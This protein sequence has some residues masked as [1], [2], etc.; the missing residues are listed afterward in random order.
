MEK[1]RTAG[2]S[3]I[4]LMIAVLIIGILAAIAIPSYNQYKVKARR[5][6][7]M[8]ALEHAGNV[9]ERYHLQKNTYV[10][11]TIPP[12]T[13]DKYVLSI[14][15]ATQNSYT[16]LATPVI[17]SA[18]DGDGI[19]VLDSSGARGWDEDHNG[20]IDVGVVATPSPP[21]PCDNNNWVS[22]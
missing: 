16:L 12:D 21:C 6:A 3:L 7:A 18:Q 10:G 5:S 19:I 20:V 13:A 2:F 9:M 4:E 17:G 1:R 8:A 11:A 14:T 15:S 22:E